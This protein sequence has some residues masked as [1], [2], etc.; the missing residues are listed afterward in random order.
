MIYKFSAE[1]FSIVD[2][3]EKEGNPCFIV[4]SQPKIGGGSFAGIKPA[5]VILSKVPEGYNKDL[6]THFARTSTHK[7]SLIDPS[8]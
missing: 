4:L 6:L 3:F 1:N 8:S 7:D 5:V 2:G